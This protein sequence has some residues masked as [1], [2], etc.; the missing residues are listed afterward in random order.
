[1]YRYI[2]GTPS[3]IVTLCRGIDSSACRVS[4]LSSITKVR[5][6]IKLRFI[7][8]V[9]YTWARGSAVNWMSCSVRTFIAAVIAAFNTTL[10]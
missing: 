9:P 1:M 3:M 8:T 5:P 2:V 10:S 4:N 7:T 6:S